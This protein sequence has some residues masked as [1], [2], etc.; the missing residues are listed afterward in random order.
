MRKLITV[1]L[2]FSLLINSSTFSSASEA[3]VVVEHFGASE[4]LYPEYS[5]SKDH[6]VL[7]IAYLKKGG[8]GQNLNAVISQDGGNSWQFLNDIS[9]KS[10]TFNFKLQVSDDGSNITIVWIENKGANNELWFKQSA[11]SGNSWSQN[12]LIP[13]P[14]VTGKS[15]LKFSQSKDGKTKLV[16]F[17]AKS[18]VST[19]FQT[20][21]QISTFDSGQTWVAAN[22][23]KHD[24]RQPYGDTFVSSD[25]SYLAYSYESY[26]NKATQSQLRFSGTSDGIN[27]S[28]ERAIDIGNTFDPHSNFIA[29]KGQDFAIFNDASDS[30]LISRDKGKTF[31]K[32]QTPTSGFSTKIWISEN[33]SRIYYSTLVSPSSSGRSLLFAYSENYG[34]NWIRLLDV[35]DAIDNETSLSASGNGRIAAIL[36]TSWGAPKDLMLQVSG[37]YGLSWSEP[38]KI[39]RDGDFV[40]VSFS[41]QQIP[42]Y[43]DEINSRILILANTQTPSSSSSSQQLIKIPFY[44]IDFDGNSNSKGTVPDGLISLDGEEVFI[45]AKDSNFTKTNHTFIGWSKSKSDTSE[46]FLPGQK[47]SN[48]TSDIKLFAIWK[49]DLSKK[50]TITCI[51]GKTIRKITDLKPKCPSGFKKK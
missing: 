36:T 16:T 8:V 45:P 12:Q 47:I 4:T 35:K 2:T 6:K 11:D 14:N 49:A 34:K 13:T 7:A 9:T 15:L 5:S 40:R 24:I 29:L 44:K 50:V 48:I 41:G 19:E 3:K 51:K 17:Y 42:I 43:L 39:T 27:W 21:F 1:F 31:Q 23:N 32:I 38:K 25:G 28:E 26:G 18:N 37:N 33:E 20:A 30:F 10:T 22:N 46:I